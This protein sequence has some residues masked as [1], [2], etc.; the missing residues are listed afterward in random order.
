MSIQSLSLRF[1]SRAALAVLIALTLLAPRALPAAERRPITETDLFRFVWIADPQISP[2]GRWIAFVRV[3]VDEKKEDYDTALWIVPTDGSTP[4]RPFTSGPRDLSPRWSPSGNWIAFV[5][6]TGKPNE[7]RRPQI[8]LIGAQGGEAFPI[9]ALP[10]GAAAPAWAP[11]G[12][13]IAFLSSSNDKDLEKARAKKEGKPMGE[14]ERESDV[15][16][17]TRAVYRLNGAG[18]NDITRPS[19]I[20]ALDAPVPGTP[21]PEPRQL[22]RGDFNAG[23]PDWSHD[24]SLVYFS[25]NRVEEPYYEQP[26]DD[27]WAVPA[28]GGDIRPVVD[29]DGPVIEWAVAPDGRRAAFSGFLNPEKRRS[30]EESDLH[31]LD[32]QSG[33][34]PQNGARNLTARFDGDVI[35]G[36]AADQHAPRGG[37]PQPIVW[38]PDGR[39]VI[40]ITAERGRINLKRFDVATGAIEP[41]TEGDQEIASYSAT[42]DASRFAL[43][44]STSTVIGDLY[45][46]DTAT[47]QKRLLYE[48]NRE[49]FSELS[50]A[51]PEEIVYPSFDGRQIQAWVQKPPGFTAGKKYPLILNIHGGPHS[52]YGYAF[53]HEMQWMA[54][55]GYLVIYPNPRG[56]SSYGQE[57]G[58]S[59]QFDFPGDDAKDLLAGVDEMVKRG[60]ADP[61]KLGV[62]GGSGG[63]ILT[64]WILT[65]TDRFKAAVSQRS[66]SDW[67]SFWYTA[68]F[69]QFDQFWFRGAPW[70]EAE[71]YARRSPITHVEKV[72]TPLMLIEGEADLRTPPTAGGEQMFRALKYL[73]R[74]V[75][76][77]RFPDETHELSR[78]G[79]PSRRIERLRHI[80]GWFDKYLKGKN[81]D[82]YDVP[83]AR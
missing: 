4:A 65:Q 23:E 32:L 21:L 42:P 68:D 10:R 66:I 67:A 7:P 41:V 11:D 17:I 44:I 2:D 79:H 71:D 51:A 72:T 28:R 80:V 59:I 82:A 3:A 39:S 57:F 24:G 61:Q 29:V 58:N 18:Y 55:Q 83:E 62:T 20:W 54:A 49:L 40:T 64:N 37:R 12:K 1:G 45:V 48:P 74:P 8:H 50:L 30:Y 33:G 60:W 13:T 35:D 22:T 34:P 9:T 5:R 69:S 36:L 27:V 47:K 77:V 14:E 15:R 70:E 81:V 38:S 46:L 16:V 63:G 6:P 26:D 73:K 31:V 19:Q 76:M 56:S 43:V 75:V 25:S 78:S 52:A 53:I